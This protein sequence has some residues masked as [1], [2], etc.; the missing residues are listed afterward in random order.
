MPTLLG[1]ATLDPPERVHTRKPPRQVRLGYTDGNGRSRSVLVSAETRR[2]IDRFDRAVRRASV[3]F[4]RRTRTGRAAA[5]LERGRKPAEA[6]VGYLC[7]EHEP[8]AQK[9]GLPSSDK[10]GRWEG[11]VV[12]FDRLLGE[13]VPWSGELFTW[14]DSHGV[15]PVCRGGELGG[16]VDGE[17]V[18]TVV[19]LWCGAANIEHRIGG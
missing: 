4:W 11:P 6:I 7:T 5:E 8:A 9:L 18:V 2:E 14:L 3:K 17:V 19:C 10:G 15:C 13:G 12:R 16:V 1:T